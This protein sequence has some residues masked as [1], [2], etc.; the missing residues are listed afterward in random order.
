MTVFVQGDFH[1]TN[2]YTGYGTLIVTGTLYYTSDSSWYGI[3]MVVGQGSVQASSSA[4]G[5]AFN[6]AMLIAQTRN[7]SG[8][9]LSGSGLGPATFN[10]SGHGNGIYYNRWCIAAAE[11]A[12]TYRV[13]S[14]HEIP[15]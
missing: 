10:S 5:G 3:V 15:Q 9:L 2:A 7:S 1:L 4:T 8:Q 11:A 13:L 14:F 6:G 12:M